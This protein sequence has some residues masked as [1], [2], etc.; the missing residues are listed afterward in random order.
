MDQNRLS[1]IS[2]TCMQNTDTAI[3]VATQRTIVKVLAPHS[4][5]I[6]D[7][8]TESHV[9]SSSFWAGRVRKKVTSAGHTPLAPGSQ[10][11]MHHAF[12]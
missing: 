10:A 9:F 1:H 4:G 11:H 7:T 6:S 8:G 3:A 5:L 12:P 2:D